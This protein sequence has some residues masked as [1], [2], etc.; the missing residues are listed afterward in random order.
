M[1]K[2]SLLLAL[3]LCITVIGCAK[4]TKG[5]EITID[6]EKT[7]T[8]PVTDKGTE[9][10][11]PSAEP[12]EPTG[13][14]REPAFDVTTAEDYGYI[15]EMAQ[16]DVRFG[17]VKAFIEKDVTACADM[18]QIFSEEYWDERNY[19]YYEWFE[20]LNLIE[21]G[22]YSVELTKDDN[23]NDELYFNFEIV[24]SDYDV[25]PIGTYRYAVYEGMM[26]KAAWVRVDKEEPELD[27]WISENI[28][29]FVQILTLD[30]ASDYW[31]RAADG[32][33]LAV[34]AQKA[35]TDNLI[36]VEA[37]QAGALAMFGIEDF[38][39]GDGFALPVDG[40]YSMKGRGGVVAE[41][42]LDKL[43]TD[44]AKSD[45]YV[46]FFADP[47]HTVKSYYVKYSFEK[48]DGDHPYKLLSVEV[49]DEG[50]YSPF[51]WSV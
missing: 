45:I 43:E 17:W 47:V 32:I 11:A 24:K 12:T 21:L 18:M 9:P 8:E 3:F 2:L 34:F 49:I 7:V 13:G 25:F 37:L 30:K 10:T 39:P 42:E 1:K 41:F 48:T 22:G 31:K 14:D 16:S 40:G 36:S 4:E 5:T 51:Y 33:Y 6:T 35:Q 26:S 23:G 29:Y 19:K 27:E 46:Q 50:K 44:G 20:Y 38:V 28:S 15:C